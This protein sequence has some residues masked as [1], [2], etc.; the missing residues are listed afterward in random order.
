MPAEDDDLRAELQAACESV[1]RQMELQQRS[2]RTMFGGRGDAMARKALQDRLAE[3]E[4]ALANL[5]AR[6]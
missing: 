5:E 4:D 2:Q 1:R 6:D 3:L